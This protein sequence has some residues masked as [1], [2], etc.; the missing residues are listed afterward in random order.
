MKIKNFFY[1]ETLLLFSFFLFFILINY[2]RIFFNTTNLEWVFIELAKYLKN[3]E[4]IFDIEKYKSTQANT[5]FLS[6]ILSTLFYLDVSDKTV[7]ILFRLLIIILTFFISLLFLIE[8]N[9][10]LNQK[11]KLILIILIISNP[12]F[13]IYLL[14][15]Y[16]ETLALQF[17]FICIYFIFKKKYLISYIFYFV[18]FLIKPFLIILSPLVLVLLFKKENKKEFY[19]ITFIFFIITLISIITIFFSQG[20]FFTNQKYSFYLSFSLERSL[21]NF[22]EYFIYCII[23]T[24]PIFGLFFI[25]NLNKKNLFLTCII[26]FIVIVISQYTY[27]ADGEINLSFLSQIKLFIKYKSLIYSFL[28]IGAIFSIIVI[29]KRK[30]PYKISIILT[31]IFLSILIIRPANRYLLYVFPFFFGMILVDIFRN[32]S[33][34]VISIFLIFNFLLYSIIN[35]MQFKYQKNKYISE[36][37]IIN[38]LK[39]NKILSYTNL[40]ELRS[41]FGYLTPEYYNGNPR[42]KYIVKKCNTNNKNYIYYSSFN[43]LNISK[44]NYCIMKN[45]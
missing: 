5:I 24:G 34:K 39:K 43:F 22:F 2:E 31:I 33:K 35:T 45:N 30:S 44:F 23:L 21:I 42:F 1:R 37:N 15:L 17:C 28:I 19:R 6:Y 14:R 12:L 11:L 16:P 41:N 10:Q 29:F 4:Y 7:L 9:I 40:N 36:V 26:S 18:S 8:K 27:T 20:N 32:Y 3:N 13:N 38:Y 25:K